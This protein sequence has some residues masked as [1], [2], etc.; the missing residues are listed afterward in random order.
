[1]KKFENGAQN[2]NTGGDIEGEMFF[3]TEFT[4]F[5]SAWS[6]QMIH[7]KYIYIIYIVKIYI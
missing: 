4:S 3:K 6:T 2:K 1:M 7:G 5:H